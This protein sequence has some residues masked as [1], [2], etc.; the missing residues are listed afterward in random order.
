M[1]QPG[2]VSRWLRKA[3]NLSAVMSALVSHFRIVFGHH[4]DEDVFWLITC[5]FLSQVPS[6]PELGASA[7]GHDEPPVARLGL[8]PAATLCSDGMPIN[9]RGN[10]LDIFARSG[11]DVE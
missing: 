10:P 6:R 11:I 9:A 2:N 4:C 1:N 5:S 8:Q 7:L 3:L